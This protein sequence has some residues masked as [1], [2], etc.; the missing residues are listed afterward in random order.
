M[1]IAICLVS[2]IEGYKGY[3]GASDW[4]VE[5][6]L[7]FE[8]IVLSSPASLVVVVVF[9]VTGT[10]LGFFGLALPASSKPEMF[11]TWFFFVATGYIQWFVVIPKVWCW[12]RNR[13]KRVT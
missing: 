9:I 8:M 5:E 1:W 11:T 6:G 13:R 2:L 10:I 7:G 12:S 3:R 4:Q